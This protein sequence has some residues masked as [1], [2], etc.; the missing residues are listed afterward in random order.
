MRTRL[1]WFQEFYP[2][3][4]GKKQ[5]QMCSTFSTLGIPA[6]EENPSW[7]RAPSTAS[8]WGSLGHTWSAVSAAANSIS[9][10]AELVQEN[11]LLNWLLSVQP[12]WSSVL[13]QSCN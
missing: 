8:T 1:N 9:V 2:A 3:Q 7:H 10:R 12:A 4:N 6:A 5:L 13:P 11:G